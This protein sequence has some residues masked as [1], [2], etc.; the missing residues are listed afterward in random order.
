M[1]ELTSDQLTTLNT[2][3]DQTLATIQNYE[4]SYVTTDAGQGVPSIY[5]QVLTST[6][7]LPAGTGGQLPT[8]VQPNRLADKPTDQTL[9]PIDLNWVFPALPFAFQ[10]NTAKRET[11]IGFNVAY[12]MHIDGSL[13]RRDDSM[14]SGQSPIKGEWIFVPPAI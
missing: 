11:E 8:A 2:A 9:S 13:F 6:D 4:E 1:A 10:V 5:L 14:W 12:S 7:P 3:A